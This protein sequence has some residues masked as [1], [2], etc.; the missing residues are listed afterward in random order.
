MGIT[1]SWLSEDFEPIETLLN[2]FYV[3]HP[4]TG[5]I[6]KNLLIEEILKWGLGEKSLLSL[7]I[8]A[9]IWF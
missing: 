3:P 7:L 4:H 9:A 1:C 5:L 6:I 8:M 2:L